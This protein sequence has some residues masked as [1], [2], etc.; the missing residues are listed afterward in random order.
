MSY[1]GAITQNVVADANNGSTAIL[2][3]KAVTSITRSDS[4]ATVTATAHGYVDNDYVYISGCLQTEYNGI[5]QVTKTGD[6]TFTYT[7]TGTPATPAT[8]DVTIKSSKAFVGTITSTLGIVGI[9]VSLKTDTTCHVYVEQSPDNA[10]VSGAPHWDISDEYHYNK[11]FGNFGTT[12]QAVSSYYRVKVINEDTVSQT[13]FRLQTALCPIV[14][15]VPRSL[16]EEGAFKVCVKG[17]HDEYGYTGMYTPSHTLQTN[18]QIRLVGAQFRSAVDTSFW[19]LAKYGTAAAATIAYYCTLSSGTDIGGHGKLNSVQTARFIIGIPNF[20]KILARVTPVVVAG[21]TRRWGGYTF[22]NY[23]FTVATATAVAGDTYTNNGITYTVLRSITGGTELLC[24]GAGAPAASGNLV[25]ASGAGTD[26][27]VF[28]T[29]IQPPSDGFYFGLSPAG[30]LSVNCVKGGTATS[31]ASGSFNGQVS[32]FY[33]DTNVHVYEIIYMLLGVNF[34]IDGVLIHTFEPTTVTLT[35]VF[36]FQVTA[37][38][39][40]S[41]VGVTSGTLEIWA[42]AILRLGLENTAPICSH[43]TTNT[44]TLCK[45]G[46]GTLHRIVVNDPTNNKITLYDNT[47]A[48]A[49]SVFAIIDPDSSATPFSLE[50]NL[51]FYTGLTVVTAG[52]PDLTIL[53]E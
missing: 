11:L 52:T 53:F 35:N 44:T 27:I 18:Q 23:L 26:P 45:T 47:S 32:E 14:E 43:I 5:F 31:V 30:A 29:W 46:A 19:N 36:T 9:Q 8:K 33:M 50:Y 12:V 17:L 25:R 22:A 6:N 20:I 13:Y 37:V 24:S 49:A 3:Y 34:Y 4:T 51:P 41:S 10:P 16:D 40:N 7:V 21:N 28:S 15:A 48:V 38:S 2:T 39:V 42:A 1:F